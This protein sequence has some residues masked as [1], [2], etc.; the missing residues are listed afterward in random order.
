MEKEIE[1]ERGKQNHAGSCFETISL[2]QLA[3]VINNSLYLY[4]LLF[5]LFD[6]LSPIY[7]WNVIKKFN[8]Q[9]AICSIYKYCIY[10][11][12]NLLSDE[13]Q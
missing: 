8:V 10:K 11:T 4:V 2:L 9:N 1:R 6:I 7:T 3:I 12:I 13:N 5:I